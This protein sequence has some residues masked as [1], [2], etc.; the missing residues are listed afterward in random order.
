MKAIVITRDRVSYAK[1]CVEALVR[2]DSITD[3]HLVDHG[4]TYPPM[5]DWLAGMAGEVK[6]LTP[7]VR[8]HCHWMANAHPRDLWSNGTL[9]S[10]VAPGERFI[11]TDHDVVVPHEESWVDQL[12]RLLDENPTVVKAGLQLRTTDL[13]PAVHHNARR[14]IEWESQYRPPRAL[15]GLP[16]DVKAGWVMASVDTTVAMYRRLEAFAID[17]AVRTVER[18]F[19]ARHL[20]WYEG[21]DD[22]LKRPE[23]LAEQRWYEEHAVHGHWHN[24]HHEFVDVHGL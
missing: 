22:T 19:E 24:D 16:S 3:I 7:S 23:A 2:S 13:D 9:A 5:L 6:L 15:W 12:A 18:R 1:Q 20:P 14:V 10:I 8:I 21:M 4:S 17:P 11:V